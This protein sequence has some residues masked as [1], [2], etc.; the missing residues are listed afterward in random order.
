MHDLG[1]IERDIARL[2]QADGFRVHLFALPRPIGP[3]AAVLPSAYNP[4]TRAHLALLDLTPDEAIPLALL[5]TRNVSKGVFGASL[6]HRV[7]M[8]LAAHDRRGFAVGASNAARI[9]D[10]G[11]ALRAVYPATRF[12]FIAG[13]DTLIRLFDPRY[14]QDMPR[15]LDD[16]F[17][18]HHV[19]TANRG[20]ADT[21]DI[22]VFLE[23]PQVRDYAAAITVRELPPECADISSTRAREDFEDEPA[24]PT[25]DAPVAE[26]IRQHGLYRE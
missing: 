4:P 2:D 14:Y 10:Q 26:Y 19:I 16:F 24:S 1:A 7:G 12:D 6:P 3:R 18:R 15:E 20:E 25:V 22:A 17:S 21:D 5:T 9:S 8:L 11:A 23:Q 13:Y